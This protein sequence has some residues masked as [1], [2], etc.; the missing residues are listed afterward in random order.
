MKTVGA[1]EIIAN[2][3][4][5]YLDFITEYFILHGGSMSTFTYECKEKA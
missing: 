3:V 4:K 2:M 5:T 1:F